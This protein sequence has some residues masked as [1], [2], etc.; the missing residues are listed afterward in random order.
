M[1]VFDFSP[2]HSCNV[3]HKREST[4]DPNLYKTVCIHK[5]PLSPPISLGNAESNYS[6]PLFFFLVSLSPLLLIQP[7]DFYE[8]AWNFGSVPNPFPH[9]VFPNFPS[10]LPPSPPYFFRTRKR[11][12][13]FSLL[14][15]LPSK[16]SSIDPFFLPQ[17]SFM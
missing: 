10:I 5:L 7:P 8:T 1:S 15:F 16:A 17:I 4:D 2:P 13:F 9:K 3:A 6:A 11:G 12:E 14:E